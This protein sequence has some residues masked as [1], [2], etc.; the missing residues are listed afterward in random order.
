MAELRVRW[1]AGEDDRPCQIVTARQAVLS[2][3]A[4]TFVREHA[5]PHVLKDDNV[6]K[7]QVP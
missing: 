2:R 7:K 6:G 4:M 1:P 5:V 3:P